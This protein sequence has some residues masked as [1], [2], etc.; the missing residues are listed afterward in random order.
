M[1][2]GSELLELDELLESELELL[3]ISELEEFET[4]MLELDDELELSQAGNS[5]TIIVH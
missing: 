2:H 4:E 1:V 5:G 3:E